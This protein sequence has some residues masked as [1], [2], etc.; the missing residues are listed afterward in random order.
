MMTSGAY[1]ISVAADKIVVNRSTIAGSI[2]VITRGFGFQGLMD[3]L[4]VERRVLTAGDSKNMMDPFGP[5]SPSDRLKQAEL[6]SAIHQHFIEAV[7]EGRGARLKQ[8]TPGLFSGT[9]WT[10]EQAVEV[11]LADEL[12]DVQSAAQ[13]NFGTKLIHEYAPRKGL[14]DALVSGVSVQ[15]SEMLKPKV[16]GPLLM[17]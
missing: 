4:G 17:P 10:G 6:L 3:K 2:G 12:G 1:F 13:K 5:Q 9:V 7:Q 11:G 15:V 8:D 14:L 16:E